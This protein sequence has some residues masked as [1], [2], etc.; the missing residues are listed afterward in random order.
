MGLLNLIE[1]LSTDL[2]SAQADNQRLRD[3]INRLKGEPGRPTI[4]PNKPVPAPDH[5]SERE[6][7]QPV[8]R[9][10]RSKL[11]RIVIDRTQEVAVDPALLPPDAEFKG[12]E[13]VVVQDVVMHTDNVLF[14]KEKWYAASTRQSYLAALPEG[15]QGEFGPGSAR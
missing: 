15:Y 2:R 7:H 5:S 13:E 4:K 10:K 1:N 9:V 12:Y 8:E 6:R 11:D 14:R 3:E